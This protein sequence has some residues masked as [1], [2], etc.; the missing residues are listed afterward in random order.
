MA[1]ALLSLAHITLGAPL[2]SAVELLT[3]SD[4]ALNTL[5]TTAY[6]QPWSDTIMS[7]E[8]DWV[9]CDGEYALC[10]YSNCT[11]NAGQAPW[12]SGVATASCPCEKHSGHNLVDINAILD[13]ATWYQPPLPSTSGVLISSGY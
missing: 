1:V 12:A 8:S 7:Y 4:F 13:E 3:A 5:N 6:G 11:A 10:Y 2:Q 9:V